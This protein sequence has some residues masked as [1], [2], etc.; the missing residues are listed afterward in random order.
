MWKSYLRTALRS[1]TRNRRFALI[2]LTGLTLG[3]ACF[4]IIVSW[5]LSELS[6]DRFHEKGDRIYQLTIRHPE[7]ILDPN[8]PY[9]LAPE[10][11]NQFPEVESYSTVMNLAL[12]SNSSFSFNYDSPARINVYESDVARVDT[13]FFKIFDF[14]LVY[15]QR[16]SLLEKPGLVVISTDI[17]D[18]YFN[19]SNPVGQN[20]LYNNSQLLTISGVVYVPENTSFDYD[21]FLPVFENLSDNWNWMDPSFLL[22][23]QG[24]D[25]EGFKVK[26]A[27]FM[28]DILPE[29]VPLP[30]SFIVGLIPI[31][32]VHLAFGQKRNVYLFGTVAFLLLL[33]ASLNYINLAS[34]NYLGRRMHET[35][36]R[37]VLGAKKSQLILV[38]FAESL[39]LV[40]SA[41]VLA[42][43]LARMVLPRIIPLF[44]KQFEIAGFHNPGFL[45]AL[46]III[47]LISLLASLYPSSFFTASSPVDLTHRTVNTGGLRSAVV[48]TA[49]VFQFTLSIALMIF[50]LIVIRQVSFTSNEDP[51]FSIDNVVGV[52]MNSG[53]RKNIM[54]LTQK[55]ETHPGIDI[56]TA[57]QAYPFNED[58]KT[59]GFEWS[60]KEVQTM[61]LWRYSVCLNNY[62]EAFDFEIISGRGYSDEFGADRGKYVINETAAKMLGFDDPVGQQI[63][64]WGRKGEI[65]GVVKDFHHVSL[66][67]EI[68]PH[69]FN[70]DSANFQNLKYLFVKYHAGQG[71]DVLSYIETV[72]N[73]FAPGF[74]FSYSFL[75]DEFRQLYTTDTNLS[76][77]LGL[78]A[79][80]TIII[81]GLSI[82]GLAFSS[83]EKK[84]REIA[85]RKVYGADLPGILS[86]IYTNLISRIGV[87]FIIAVGLSLVVAGKW[88]Q[89][90]EYRISLDILMFILPA[91]LAFI[92]AGLATLFAL[93]RPVRQNPA[94][95]L[96]QE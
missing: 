94:Y 47:G 18:R 95:L 8:C 91:M 20:I 58:Y 23:K 57:G 89:T 49:A 7:G 33:I 48:L 35:G 80:L 32:K 55:L 60:L 19:G 82:Y 11:M 68:L 67:K 14:P 10:M 39:I 85:V 16:K 93:W 3:L 4:I 90:F 61:D 65:I 64:M 27:S 38:F 2:N 26:I 77:I 1:L 45:A 54:A 36:M 31:H 88:L 12:K 92:I 66:H 41:M 79:I 76:R 86:L 43:V 59:G 81:S 46:L 74:P 83:V 37:K 84:S 25:L 73:D 40:F 52:R 63:T 6:F 21:F 9:A 42:Q 13:T 71:K 96:K 17:A 15:G 44:G 56:A 29:E 62:L 69:I 24:I 70:T 22:L 87:S 75:Q 28:N 50:T 72:C 34:A 78:F 30:R 51:G 5:I 53:L